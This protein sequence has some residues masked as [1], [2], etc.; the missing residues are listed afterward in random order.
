MM[1]PERWREVERLFHA[2]R[3]QRAGEERAA[4]LREACRGDDGLRSEVESL[5]ARDDSASDFIEAPAVEVA[6]WMIARE[7]G[8]LAAEQMV[9]RYQVLSGC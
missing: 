4:Y 2:A 1:T 9:D 6:A 8:G 5:L 3:G 7:L